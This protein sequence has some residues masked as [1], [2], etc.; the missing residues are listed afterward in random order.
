[1]KFVKIHGL[2]MGFQGVLDVSFF[3]PLKM[4]LEINL[5]GG[6]DLS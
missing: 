1:M 6:K 4:V 5:K 3:L 2:L